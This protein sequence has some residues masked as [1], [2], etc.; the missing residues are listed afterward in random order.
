MICLAPALYMCVCVFVSHFIFPTINFKEGYCVFSVNFISRRMKQ[1][2]FSL[3]TMQEIL[4]QINWIFYNW[5]YRIHMYSTCILLLQIFPFS[6]Q[7]SV[8]SKLIFYL[9]HMHMLSFNSIS[10]IFLTLIL[11]TPPTHS[12]SGKACFTLHIFQTEFT[13]IH[14]LYGSQFLRIRGKVPRLN[15]IP[16]Q[17]YQ[18]DVFHSSDDIITGLWSYWTMHTSCL[19]WK[20]C[21]QVLRWTVF[22]GILLWKKSHTSYTCNVY[23][24][25][26][27]IK[28]KKELN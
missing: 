27:M 20:G 25:D 17:L 1:S 12:M 7:N 24:Q 21:G 2:T 23:D 16:T 9:P 4:K 11:L 26:C 8:Q 5:Q 18:L 19:R 10:S 14:N 22:R 13:K 28:S 15:T 3:K 6:N